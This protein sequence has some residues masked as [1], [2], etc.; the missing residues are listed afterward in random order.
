MAPKEAQGL[1]D[2]PC[3]HVT[4]HGKRDLSGMMALRS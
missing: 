1:L 4:S 3:E 2:G